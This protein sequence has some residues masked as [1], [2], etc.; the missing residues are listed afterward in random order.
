MEVIKHLTQDVSIVSHP[1]LIAGSLLSP[2]NRPAFA[3]VR[4]LEYDILFAGCK[5]QP[6][7]LATACTYYTVAEPT[8]PVSSNDPNRFAISPNHSAEHA[9]GD[10]GRHRLESGEDEPSSTVLSAAWRRQAN[11]LRRRWSDARTV[12]W[13]PCSWATLPSVLY[14]STYGPLFTAHVDGRGCNA[15]AGDAARRHEEANGKP[16]T[17]RPNVYESTCGPL[18]TAYVNGRGCDANAGDAARRHEEANGKPSEQDDEYDVAD[19]RCACE[20]VHKSSGRFRE[21][22]ASCLSPGQIRNAPI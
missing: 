4:P 2:G 7:V 21:C 9:R 1:Y 18:F 12:S 19:G 8:D 15:T 22:A 17:T 16:W 3:V 10:A 14:E 20:T 13:T 11:E 6:H 5:Q